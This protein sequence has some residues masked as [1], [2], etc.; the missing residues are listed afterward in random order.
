MSHPTVGVARSGPKVSDQLSSLREELPAWMNTLFVY[1]FY[2]WGIQV[3]V[4]WYEQNY[5]KYYIG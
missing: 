1:L 5:S 4:G 3:P 2:D